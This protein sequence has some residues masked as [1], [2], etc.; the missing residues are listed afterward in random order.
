MKYVCFYNKE[1]NKSMEQLLNK[2]SI[3][4]KESNI[5]IESILLTPEQIKEIFNINDNDEI[6]KSYGDFGWNQVKFY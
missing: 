1:E 5:F 6:I 4:D 2:E 3:I